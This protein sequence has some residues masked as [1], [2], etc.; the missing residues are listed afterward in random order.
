MNKNLALL[1]GLAATIG[2]LSGTTVTSST[3]G[4]VTS[5]GGESGSGSASGT[6]SASAGSSGVI[7][8]TSGGSGSSSSGGNG[9]GTTGAPGVLVWDGPHFYPVGA[10]ADPFIP[11]D[12]YL[13]LAVGDL[14]NDKKLDLVVLHV[15][16]N[17][18]NV[19]LGNGD[20]SF[21]PAVSYPIGMDVSGE[22]QLYLADFNGDG[23]LDL[24]V[25]GGGSAANS[26]TTKAA[27]FLGRGDGTFEP[28]TY[29]P[30]L[31]G[32]RGIT[33]GD[34]NGDGK[35]DL[36]TNLLSQ[37]Q[38]GFLRGDGDG[39]FEP[40]EMSPATSAFPYSRWITAG[41]FN[42]DHQLD[43]AVADGMGYK[44]DAGTAEITVLFGNG[45]GTFTLN[46]HYPALPTAASWGGAPPA[47][48]SG[49][50]VNPED[51]QA[52]D[53][54]DDGKLDL[55]ES[56]Y[57]HNI[58]IYLNNGDGS[59]QPAVG[60]VTGEYPRCVAAA[61][62]NGDGVTDLV[63]GNIGCYGLPDA[64]IGISGN[65]APSV[66]SVA[67]LIGNGGG[68]FQ[69]PV[70]LKPFLFPEWIVVGDFDGDGRPD[71]AITQVQDGHSLAVYLNRTAP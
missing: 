32:T 38:I 29:S 47:V 25:P 18:V 21:K 54:N 4:S 48:N 30:P 5:A 16:D 71:L 67:I 55:I 40:L 26:Y 2:C 51:I 61:D 49:P 7:A 43:V 27:I 3:A 70:L 37:G 34:A 62:M 24:A 45:D 15:S 10:D 17:T 39:G 41:D 20:G 22:G 14:N 35:P 46:D 23:N 50:V 63:V 53:V 42:G 31:G 66:G 69:A 19:L 64:G 56:L 13:G 68:T 59:F 65:C 52:L 57:D 11:N 60:Y 33:V 1:I 6:A 28:T 36:L 9:S 12:A 58:D 44:N 8:T